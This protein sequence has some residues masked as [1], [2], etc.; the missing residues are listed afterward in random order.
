M[1]YVQ[2]G[3]LKNFTN[4]TVVDYNYRRM[5]RQNNPFPG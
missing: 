4:K 5:I 2:R 3:K 1:I